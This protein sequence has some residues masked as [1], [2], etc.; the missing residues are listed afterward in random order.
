MSGR[1]RG[2]GRGAG[3]GRG[4]PY[5]KS[6][7]TTSEAGKKKSL[8]DY[9]YQTGT[10]KQASEFH[11]ITKYLINH[12]RKTYKNGDDIGTA[13]KERKEFNFTSMTPTLKTS[14]ST[15]SAVKDRENRQFEIIYEAQVNSYI[16]RKDI[17]ESNRGNAYAF[18]F[19]QCN[20]AMQNKLQMRTDYESSIEKNPIKLLDAIEEHSISYQENKYEMRVITDAL[21]NFV[22][23]KQ[24]EDESL[25]DYTSRFKSARDVLSA[26]I[27]GSL[28]LTK[29][30]KDMPEYDPNDADKVTKCQK[31]AYEQLTAYLYLENADRNKYGSLYTSL[32]SQYSLSNNQYPKTII[33]ATNVLSNH[34]FDQAYFDAKQK[35]S[36]QKGPPNP[37]PN[38]SDTPNDIVTE[39]TFAQMEGSCYCCGKP[40]HKSNKCK[41]K[42]KPKSEWAINKIPQMQQLNQQQHSQTA[43]QG[44]TNTD[45]AS[46]QAPSV[47]PS[48]SSSTPQTFAW[49][50]T[51]VILA[52]S[53]AQKFGAM[54]TWILLDSCSSVDLFCDPKMVTNIREVP[55]TLVLSTNAGQLKT[56]LQATVPGYGT[57]WF[58]RE[59]MT[60]VY[61]LALLSNVF[62]VTYDSSKEQAF[63]VHTQSGPIRFS[64][65]A[66]NLF[67]YTPSGKLN[68][69]QWDACHVNTIEENE[70]F[71][72]KRQRMRAKRARDLLKTV[73]FPT[74]SDLKKA[75]TMNSIGNCPV[76]KLDLEIAEE[77]YGPDMGTLKGKTT[78][79]KPKPVVSNIV[80]IPPELTAAQHKV[81]LCFDTMFVNGYPYFTTISKRIMFRTAAR[82]PDKE[83]HSYQ[84]ALFR[85]IKFYTEAGF[86]VTKVYCDREFVAVVR[87]LP[88]HIQP[89]VAAAHEHVP[90]AERNNR[91]IKERI[92]AHFHSLPFKAIP[93][94]MQ[95]ILVM[96]ATR[97]LN[98][99]PPKHGCSSYYSPRMI[100][101][102]QPLD[103][104]QHCSIPTF[105][106]VQAHDEPLRKNS[107][108]PRTLDAIFLRH[109]HNNDQG[110]YE[111]LHLATGE[112][113]TR[114][115]VTPVPITQSA[116]DAV[117]AMA[118][119]EGFKGLQL[120]SKTGQILYDSAWIAGV[121]YDDDESYNNNDAA[122]DEDNESLHY[123]DEVDPNELADIMEDAQDQDVQQDT[124]DQ[125]VQQDEQED[126]DP[127]QQESGED[128]AQPE[129]EDVHQ[130]DSES[131]NEDSRP[132]RNRQPPQ[133]L[134]PTFKGKSYSQTDDQ[135]PGVSTQDYTLEEAKVISMIICQFKER[136][137]AKRTKEG[138]QFVTT[139]SLKKGVAKFKDKGVKSVMKEMQQLIDRDC[140]HPIHKDSL[141]QTEMKRALESL[142]F[143]VEKRD[144]TIKSRH[145]A[146]GST[147]RDYMSRE[148][149][150]SPTVSTEA[151]LLTATIEAHEGRDVATCDI[152]NAFVQT[153]L[154]SQDKDGNRTIMKIRGVL[155]DILCE[156][157]ESYKPFVVREGKSQQKVVYVHI[158][159]AIY[160]LL[161]SAMLYYKKWTKD[162]QKYGFEINPYD[163]C[164][165]NKMVN[166]KQLTVSFHVDDVKISHMEP[167]IVDEFIQWVKKKYGQIGE[168]KA[169]RGKIHEYLGMT[170][171]YSVKGRVT[172]NMIQYVTVM[173]NG[174][175]QAHLEGPKVASPWNDNLFKVDDKSPPLTKE[176]AEQFH[177]T[178]AQGLFLCKRGRPDISPAIAYLTTRVR[179]PNRDDW[180]K[181]VRMMKYL[182][183][184]INDCLTLQADGSGKLHWHVDAAFAVHPDFR[185]HTG[186]TLTMG[187]GAISSVSKKQG[188][189]TR[190][191]TEAEVV[192]ADEMVGPMLWTRRFL[193]AQGYNVTENI[194][195]QDNQSAML[196]EKNG[197]KSAG[198][199]SRHLNIRFFFVAD[200]QEKGHITVKYCP[201]DDMKADYMT[202]PL[203]GS[204]FNTHRRDIMNLPL[205]AH[206][207]M[208]ACMC[209]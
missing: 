69:L 173:I 200:Q 205:A 139:Y 112:V 41:F 104:K 91:T 19:S 79:T 24:K 121:D 81:D 103:Y 73:G 137:Q 58:S 63:I 34:R 35:K 89:N 100:I 158:T 32:S 21:K 186:G 52:I 199:R 6:K 197:R 88:T 7:S 115:H 111:L 5:N 202:K 209:V 159:R 22:N 46:S 44:A 45:D 15:D 11:I 142:I 4:K 13:L 37:N 49:M 48:Q 30:V 117:N 77:I 76:T 87:T 61:S 132:T 20:K 75:L 68:K 174:F 181:L 114:T 130:E 80:D 62:R 149:V 125:D 12:I 167:K 1:G 189:N 143:L 43:S 138:G 206:L 140:F 175:P 141:N 16:T 134:A 70:T 25:I 99:F 42:N 146:N 170:L 10:A 51:Q 169:I 47:A 145:C 78:R 204:K 183:Q 60:N 110:G 54:I 56:N 195:Y 171:D 93:L 39:M 33:S 38:P 40:G 97:K 66:N 155:V 160:G 59:A 65:L 86:D 126:E 151:T 179:C 17:Y 162:L 127:I 201:T 67:A 129:E 133:Y 163:P 124:Q 128:D 106:F 118:A 207:M 84:Q 119:H 31:E 156:M 188:M 64:K 82:V 14:N 185:S 208:A 95:D 198:K 157:D 176:E 72:T 123:H 27:G 9:V 193:E 147:Q 161:V 96:E 194:L 85:V 29:F 172:I 108:A 90:E 92:R 148:D 184:T 136:L 131:D 116:I 135:F 113:I 8:S 191:S 98:Y 109:I 153:E 2:R 83:T 203:H 190:S 105:S 71:F 166:G 57:V 165:A 182:K 107:Q 36:K 94:I 152:P 28:I 187:K 144:G 50:H 180:M 55:E 168:V 196:L 3:R 101:N 53:I 122:D 150:S 177:T 26:Q 102:H 74:V 120:L 154:D 178:T 23:L 192:A 18:L 164:V